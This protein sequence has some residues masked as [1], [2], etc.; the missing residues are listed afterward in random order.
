MKTSDKLI[1]TFLTIATFGLIW[2]K[3]NKDKK[4][5]KNTIYQVNKIPCD[6]NKI[7]E[8]VGN[9]NITGLSKT[10]T[11]LIIG[12]KDPNE[13]KQEELKNLKGVS[14]LFI[15]SKTIS[16]IFGEYTSAI[17]EELKKIRG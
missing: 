10:S 1:M 12:I 6:A 9:G 5:S 13:I 7:I 4:H 14:G 2:I 8:Y 15:S 3:W 16:L 11:R 17:L